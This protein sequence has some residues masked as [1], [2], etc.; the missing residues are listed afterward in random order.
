MANRKWKIENRNWKIENRKW[1]AGPVSFFWLK[2]GNGN[3]QA[4]FGFP[5]SNFQF[6]VSNF[7]FLIAGF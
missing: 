1:K 5:V 4:W 6:P 2:S 7:Q 3:S